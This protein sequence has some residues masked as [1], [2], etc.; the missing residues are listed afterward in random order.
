MNPIDPAGDAVLGRGLAF[1]LQLAGGVV[2]MRADEDQVAQ[3]IG[4]ILRTVPGERLMRPDF[5]AG[6]DRLAFEP[7]GAVSAALLQ[8]QIRQALVQLEPRIDLLRVA[9]DAD[10]AQGLLRATLSYRLRQ[11]DAVA[12]MVYPFY[13]ERG[14]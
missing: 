6:T 14:E 9:V 12:N 1:P 3:A 13:V 10:P 5:G 4:L 2:G 11:T 8:H 7:V